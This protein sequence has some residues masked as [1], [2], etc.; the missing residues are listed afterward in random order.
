[1]PGP[2]TL[3]SVAR[4]PVAR[5]DLLL[6][7]RPGTAS[8]PFATHGDVQLEPSR[9]AGSRRAARGA[10]RCGDRRDGAVALVSSTRV[11]V[12][13]SAEHR[14]IAI[15][16]P[17]WSAARRCRAR[18]A[19]KLAGTASGRPRRSAFGPRGLLPPRR[20][21]EIGNPLVRTF[22]QL[23]PERLAGRSS[24]PASGLALQLGSG[25]S[26]APINDLSPS[27][28]GA[29]GLSATP[30][31]SQAGFRADPSGCWSGITPKRRR[32]HLAE[33]ARAPM[34]TMTTRR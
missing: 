22:I 8:V 9:S 23:L 24:A 4:V 26:A 34:V 14:T 10:S 2:P 7:E 1:L 19:D 21:A 33:P 6:E 18:L 31:R 11:P 12:R 30:R 27:P 15:A 25:A 3:S 17:A 32:A 13:A 20:L 29:G 16:A 5:A 28:P